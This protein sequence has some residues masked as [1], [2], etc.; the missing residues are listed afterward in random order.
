MWPRM[1]EKVPRE[2]TARLW[3][4]TGSFSPPRSWALGML[5]LGASWAGPDFSYPHST[6]I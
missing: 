2:N 3:I 5:P 1:A 4:I 6:G